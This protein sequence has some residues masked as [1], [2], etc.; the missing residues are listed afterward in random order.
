MKPTLASFGLAVAF[1]C[2][3]IWAPL[4][5]GYP[6]YDD[7]NGNGC[8]QCHGDFKGGPT[9]ILHAVHTAVYGIS[10]CNLCHPNGPGS[11]P[12]RTYTSGPGGGLGCAGCHGRDYGEISPNSGQPKATGY[13][14]R[15]FHANNGV[16]VCS[17]CHQPGTLGHSNP[18]P[19]IEPEN[20]KPPYYALKLTANLRN[21]CDSAQEDTG[22]DTDFVGLDNDGDGAADWPADADC[23]IPTTTTTSTTTTT[24]LPPVGCGAAPAVGCV[25]PG[26]GIL[27]VGEKKAGKEKI[28][29]V[30]KK[31]Q[32]AVLQSQYG[33]PATGDTSYAICIY[34]DLD[35]LVGEI[36]VARAGALCGS[37]PV[38]C[39]VAVKTK[40]YKYKDKS[41]SADGILKMVLMGG[42]SGKGKANAI[43]KNNS[44]KGQNALPTGI[45]PLLQ[46]N[47]HATVQL[48]TSNADCFGVTVTDV[49]K[50][51][52]AVFKAL[53]P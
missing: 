14:L 21:P 25:A 8:V 19:P 13:G 18:F 45:A 4:A 2:S 47:S 33:D 31:L 40:G 46:N 32:S 9:Q 28:K 49:K 11:K 15:Q 53:G 1:L 30:L 37:P 16:T 34:D 51:D 10:E 52:G 42:D 39:W 22:F 5:H 20:V 38:P 3:V 44:S 36:S 24:T 27:L 43:G 29:V 48:L 26:K 35:Q 50:A 17:I 6:M 7:G 41:A 12:V 23:G